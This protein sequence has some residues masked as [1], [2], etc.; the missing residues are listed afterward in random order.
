MGE[1]GLAYETDILN[2]DFTGGGPA[3]GTNIY[4]NSRIFCFAVVLHVKL[5]IST[6]CLKSN[7][8]VN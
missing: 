8:T 4:S 1:P 2:P 6:G 7:Q 3:D 5:T